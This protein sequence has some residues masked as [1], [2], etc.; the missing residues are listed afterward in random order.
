MRSVKRHLLAAAGAAIAASGCALALDTTGLSGGAGSSADSGIQDA[1]TETGA[2]A[3]SGGTLD[4]DLDDDSIVVIAR[5]TFSRTAIDE[6]GTAEKGGAWSTAGA[7]TAFSVSSG[8]ARIALEPGSTRRAKLTDVAADDADVQLVITTDKVTNDTAYLG[9]LGRVIGTTEYRCRLVI[10]GGAAHATITR[11]DSD[12]ALT[13][14][15]VSAPL[16]PVTAGEPMGVRCQAAGTSPTILRIKLWR[17]V[18][19]EPAAWTLTASD[20]T[21]SF[22]TTGTVGV[23]FYMG[24][25]ADGTVVVSL[26]ELL[27]RP[28]SRMP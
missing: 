9:V 2:E 15:A 7:P 13:H 5:D 12:E 1:T 21:P 25:A 27:V 16:F 23:H 6:L 24:S 3:G 11:A 14:L 22:Q 26:D 4:A 8:A 10:E 17:A 28:A 20:A 19:G 18:L